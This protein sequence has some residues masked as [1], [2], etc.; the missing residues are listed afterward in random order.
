MVNALP[1]LD[2]SARL[3]SK[4]KIAKKLEM[5]VDNQVWL[6]RMEENATKKMANVNVPKFS[7]K[8]DFVKLSTIKKDAQ[9]I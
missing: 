4:E 1:N 7:N 6:A 9:K 3:D 2:A 8:K 5:T